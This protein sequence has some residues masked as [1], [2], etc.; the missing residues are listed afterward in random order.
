MWCFLRP[1]STFHLAKPPGGPGS[2]KA[3]SNSMVINTPTFPWPAVFCPPMSVLGTKYTAQTPFCVNESLLTKTKSSFPRP[4][5]S[6]RT[7]PNNKRM[8]SIFRGTLSP[9]LLLSSPKVRNADTRKS[10]GEDR[11]SVNLYQQEFWLGV[12]VSRALCETPADITE[13]GCGGE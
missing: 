4:P 11:H 9:L 13:T 10:S 2:Q 6:P 12:C 1:I 3:S 8:I 5:P 7:D